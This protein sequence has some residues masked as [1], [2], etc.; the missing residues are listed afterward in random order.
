MNEQRL[1][2]QTTQRFPLIALLSKKTSQW[3]ESSFRV[4]R[5]VSFAPEAIRLCGY[6]TPTTFRASNCEATQ[7][8]RSN[9]PHCD[10]TIVAALFKSPRHNFFCF[11]NPCIR[12]KL[13]SGFIANSTYPIDGAF[14]TDKKAKC[15]AHQKK[16]QYLIIKIK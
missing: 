4:Q 5:S 7:P 9:S 2:T 14:S 3:D 11:E 8:C 10:T 15:P 1:P 6:F 12:F 16:L 13:D